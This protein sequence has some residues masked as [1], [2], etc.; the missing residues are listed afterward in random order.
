[1]TILPNPHRWWTPPGAIEPLRTAG[2][3]PE[4]GRLIVIVATREPVRVVRVDEVHHIN[5]SEPTQKAWL[6]A[7]E[8][9]PETWSG[10]EWAVMVEPP[11]HPAVSGKDRTGFL[12]SPWW[13]KPQWFYLSDPYPACIACGLLWPCP[14]DDRNKAAEAAMKELERLGGVL[15]GC[16]WACSEP[17]TKSHKS[18]EFPGEN[19]ALPGAPPPVFHIAASRK[20]HRG[21]C[22]SEAISYEEKWIAAAPGRASRLVCAGVLFRHYQASECTFGSAC[23]GEDAEHG[24]Y[25]Y[26]TTIVGTF[27]GGEALERL[28]HRPPT[29]CGQRGCR[30]AAPETGPLSAS[31]A[32]VAVKQATAKGHD[33]DGAHGGSGGDA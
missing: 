15:P 29:S 31:S 16:C 30:G 27:E 19:L 23:P 8:T 2:T 18:I 26:C 11:Y 1:V 4:V 21:T 28:E 3:R 10:R 6:Q 5:W 14:C 9:D 20:S 22:R 25:A 24:R 7:K 33:P 17:I 32:H 13:P 12:L